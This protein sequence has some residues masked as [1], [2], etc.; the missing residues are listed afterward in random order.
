MKLAFAMC[1]ALL[2]SACQTIKV[3]GVEIDKEAQLWVTAATIGGAFL[4]ADLASDDDAEK[5]KCKTL[6]S[7]PV[8]KGGEITC[9]IPLD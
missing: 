4:I 3:Q 8:E 1:G 9:A 7:A 2:L 5:T 6:T